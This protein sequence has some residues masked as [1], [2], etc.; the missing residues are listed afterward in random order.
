MDLEVIHTVFTFGKFAAL[1]PSSTN[2]HNPHCLQKLYEICVYLLYVMGFSASIYAHYRCANICRIHVSQFVR[3]ESVLLCFLRFDR[4]DE[5]EEASL[6]PTDQESRCCPVSRFENFIPFVFRFFADL[7]GVEGPW[8]P[9]MLG[10]APSLL[11][12]LESNLKSNEFS[13]LSLAVRLRVI[14]C[15]RDRFVCVFF[16]PDPSSSR[17]LVV[18]VNPFYLAFSFGFPCRLFFVFFSFGPS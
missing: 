18:V 10:D 16:V 17:S 9:L 14:A 5:T 4:V 8:V 12:H 15:Y 6:I 2:N 11:E 7:A 3:F 13:K 1:T